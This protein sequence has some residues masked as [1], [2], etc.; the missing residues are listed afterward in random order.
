MNPHS[1]RL[2][3]MH[4]QHAPVGLL[5][6]CGKPLISGDQQ[7]LLRLSHSPQT[8]VTD[9]FIGCPA[10]IKDVQAS[11]PQF[12]HG[13]QRYVLVYEYLHAAL[14]DDSIGDTCSS[15]SDAA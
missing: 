1:I 6:L 7:A 2:A 11:R 3:E 10:D 4:D 14:F 5:S 15:A 12:A 9:A 8:F 13:H